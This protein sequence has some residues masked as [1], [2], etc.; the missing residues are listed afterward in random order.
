M[1]SI[2]KT[3]YIWLALALILG[4]HRGYLALW[5][6]GS[7]APCKIYPYKAALLPPAEAQ[8]LEEGIPIL[9]E[10]HLESLL[11]NYMS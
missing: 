10:S 2:R 8:K 4:T 6:T 7:P 5:E 11:S 3:F 9:N 1:I